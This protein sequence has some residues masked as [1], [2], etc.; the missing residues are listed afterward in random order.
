VSEMVRGHGL[1]RSRHRGRRKNQLQMLFVAAATNLK[2]LALYSLVSV[3]PKGP[4]LY[5][6]GGRGLSIPTES[7]EDTLPDCAHEGDNVSYGPRHCHSSSELGQ[8]LAM[9]LVLNVALIC[10]F[11]EPIIPRLLTQPNYHWT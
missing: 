11:G 3:L 7:E 4:P 1:R 10:A 2:R 8:V 6:N 5:F 9:G